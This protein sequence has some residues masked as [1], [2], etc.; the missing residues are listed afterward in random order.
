MTLIDE[1]SYS[2]LTAGQEYI[3][4]G[5]LMDKST[6]KALLNSDGKEITASATFTAKDSNG[7]VKV[8]FHF[9]ASDL[10]G[11]TL[12]VFEDLY[13]N[14]TKLASHADLNDAAQSVFVE[15]VPA[16]GD[17]SNIAVYVIVC[18]FSAAAL[19]GI[20]ICFKRRKSSK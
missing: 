9:D 13:C 15:I 4:T 16:T 17:N 20:T 8:K 19:I 3:V 6:G 2:N 1:V 12:V 7:C 18:A 10:G 11:K 14:D 5:K